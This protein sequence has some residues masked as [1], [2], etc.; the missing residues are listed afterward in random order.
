MKTNR[1]YGPS[2]LHM[3]DRIDQADYAINPDEPTRNAVFEWHT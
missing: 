3:A 2:I 1:I